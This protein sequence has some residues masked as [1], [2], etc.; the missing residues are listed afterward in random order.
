MAKHTLKTFGVNTAIYLKYVWLFFNVMQERGNF[1]FSA[2]VD[3][4]P[5]DGFQ[6]Y[7]IV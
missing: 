6:S 2:S 4:N 1:T 5:P 7:K 3:H